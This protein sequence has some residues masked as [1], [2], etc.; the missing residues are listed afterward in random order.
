[1]Q[2]TIQKITWAYVALFVVL[3]GMEFMPFIYAEN[4][5]IFGAFKLDPIA[6]WL[7]VLSGVWALGAALTSEKACLYYF[8]IFG[9]A[10]FLDGVVGILAGKAYL[11][12]R[13]F[14]PDAVPVADLWTR[15]VLNTPHIV[16]G[17]LAMYIGFVLYKKLNKAP[18][19]A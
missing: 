13:L 14:D 3:V 4:G 11:N 5:R 16:I 15:L 12:L 7:H 8:R 9:T 18:V 17:G 2:L 10:Y 1:M 19:T 6:N